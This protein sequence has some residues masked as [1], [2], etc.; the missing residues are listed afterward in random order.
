MRIFSGVS[1]EHLVLVG[2]L[3]PWFDALAKELLGIGHQNIDHY[4]TRGV[5][6]GVDMCYMAHGPK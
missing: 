3:P 1:T 5:K 4:W 2:L 6:S